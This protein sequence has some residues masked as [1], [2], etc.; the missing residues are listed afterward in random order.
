MPVKK[1]KQ[2]DD[3]PKKKSTE[4]VESKKKHGEQ[5][6]SASNYST[7]DVNAL[8]DILEKHRLFGAHAWNICANKYTV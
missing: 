6:A 5:S 7:K 1:Q 4:D 3:C 8:L 2:R